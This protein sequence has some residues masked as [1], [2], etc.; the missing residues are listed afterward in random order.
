MQK[1]SKELKEIDFKIDNSYP[2]RFRY[3]DDDYARENLIFI[4]NS[5]LKEKLQKNSNLAKIL[6][7]Y[8]KSFCSSIVFDGDFFIA[9]NYPL[10]FLDVIGCIDI[11][12]EVEKN[13]FRLSERF[14]INNNDLTVLKS[15]RLKLMDW[16]RVFLSGHKFENDLYNCFHPFFKKILVNDLTNFIDFTKKNNYKSLESNFIRSAN[17]ES[18]KIKELF[19]KSFI[20][21]EKIFV[22]RFD[23]FLRGSG[24]FYVEEYDISLLKKQLKQ[25]F[26]FVK[27]SYENYFEF[28]LEVI[29][30]S[31][32]IYGKASSSNFP[33]GQVALIATKKINSNKKDLKSFAANHH[34]FDILDF[35]P[36][37]NYSKKIGQNIDGFLSFTPSTVEAIDLFSDFLTLER[38]YVSPPERGASASGSLHCFHILNLKT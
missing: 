34:T 33:I 32:I 3:F 24:S 28:G 10:D 7:D 27:N 30:P 2:E 16:I 1:N 25:F 18:K 5:S 20:E 6:F 9:Q 4:R 38:R 17:Y 12:L 11:L 37:L 15:Y 14:L 29:F 35:K 22:C 23:I 19:R 13:I 36:A 21:N 26:L 8:K 31:K